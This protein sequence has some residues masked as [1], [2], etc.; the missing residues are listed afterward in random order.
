MPSA[1]RTH[2]PVVTVLDPAGAVGDAA[3][4]AAAVRG[5]RVRTLTCT[6]GAATVFTD[7]VTARHGDLTDEALL[8]E[9]VTGADAIILAL[10]ESLADAP[11][12]GADDLHV[13][14]ALIYAMRAA[15]IERLIVTMPLDA[16]RLTL[17]GGRAL[18]A[19]RRGRTLRERAQQAARVLRADHAAQRELLAVR[20]AYELVRVSGLRFTVLAHP[21]VIVAPGPAE[22]ELVAA[23][24][25]PS[26]SAEISAAMVAEQALRCALTGAHEG[27]TVVVTEA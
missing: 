17:S 20:R 11:Y 19:P 21:R 18:D 23:S 6:P 22:V 2:S 27:D 25:A 24:I 9:T 13:T 15:G 8:A 16:L 12:R 7:A 10:G 14:E 5:C 3:M 26:A 4:R 1:S